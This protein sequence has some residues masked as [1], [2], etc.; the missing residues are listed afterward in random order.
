MYQSITTDFEPKF[1]KTDLVYIEQYNNAYKR[2]AHYPSEDQERAIRMI[3][4]EVLATY[5]NSKAKTKGG[6]IGRFLA[7]VLGVV[8]RFVKIK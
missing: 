6:K 8:V 3:L 5:S 2:V 4:S 1:N 7:M